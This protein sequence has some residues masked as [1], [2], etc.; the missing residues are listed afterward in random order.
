M[1]AA[2]CWDAHASKYKDGAGLQPQ[3]RNAK[4]TQNH[5]CGL[6]GQAVITEM[7]LACS[8]SQGRPRVHNQ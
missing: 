4:R 6:G 8:G 3:P 7:A 5:E 1:C 2:G